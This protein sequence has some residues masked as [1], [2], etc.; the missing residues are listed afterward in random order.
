VGGLLLDHYWWGSIF[1]INIPMAAVG[2][3]ACLF[4]LPESR[5]PASPRIDALSTAYSA[6]GLAALVF[7][8]I[9]GPARGWTSGWVLGSFALSAGLVSALV[10]RERRAVRPLLDLGLLGRRV[11][12]FNVLA[13]TLGTFVFA[14]LPSVLRARFLET[15]GADAFGTGVRLLPMMGGLLVSARASTPLVRRLGSR[16]VV[17]AGLT[18]L[19]F[20]ALLGARTGA[21]TGYG[22]IA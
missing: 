13:A 7:G 11:F 17:V 4:L 15:G 20:A 3:V 2:I 21:G 14:G 1:L 6:L 19:C 9:E 16:P 8:I 22:F 18:V 12:L 10:L 5:D